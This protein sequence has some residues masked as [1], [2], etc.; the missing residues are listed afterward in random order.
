MGGLQP[1]PA[2]W[3]HH[4]QSPHR[5]CS[6]EH[7]AGSVLPQAETQTTQAAQK[8]VQALKQ[9]ELTPGGPKQNNSQEKQGHSAPAETLS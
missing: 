8:G 4:R 5:Y 1:E 6:E 9:E 2:A 7:R 3:I